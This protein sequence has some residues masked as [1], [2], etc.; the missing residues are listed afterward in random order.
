MAWGAAVAAARVAWVQFHAAERAHDKAAEVFCL[1]GGHSGVVETELFEAMRA[2]G[3]AEEAAYAV[4][5][6]AAEVA[7]SA[8]GAVCD[9]YDHAGF[10]QAFLVL[11]A[12]APH[13]KDWSPDLE[14]ALAALLSAPARTSPQARRN[15]HRLL[16]FWWGFRC[17]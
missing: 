12:I 15:P 1:Y 7:V 8:R 3:T 5:D 13:W 10:P 16:A 14:D 6:D 2:A 17:P 4:Y 9:A 11:E